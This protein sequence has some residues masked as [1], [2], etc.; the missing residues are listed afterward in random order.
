M[1]AYHN[2]TDLFSRSQIN[3][4]HRPARSIKEIRQRQLEMR[5]N[6]LGIA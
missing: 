4:V 5:T 3:K 2:K 6:R 1:K